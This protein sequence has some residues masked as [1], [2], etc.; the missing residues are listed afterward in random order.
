MYRLQVGRLF[1]KSHIDQLRKLAGSK[2]ADSEP[3]RCELPEIDF[4]ETPD[5]I[6]GFGPKKALAI[7]AKNE[8]HQNNFK[9]CIMVRIYVL[10]TVL[11]LFWTIFVL[12]SRNYVFK[13]QLTVNKA[14][15]GQFRLNALLL[16]Q[17]RVL[18]RLTLTLAL[19][20]G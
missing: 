10:N 13:S 4:A 11:Y 8:S 15:A 6:E 12:F 14:A 5:A 20:W 16:R 7:L 17:T 18:F 9:F 3:K 19:A 1:L 2:V